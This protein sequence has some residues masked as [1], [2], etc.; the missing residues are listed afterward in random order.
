M[1]QKF[2]G[3][4][5]PCPDDAIPRIVFTTPQRWLD[6]FG[7]G[8]SIRF[9]NR[10]W[11]T[12]PAYLMIKTGQDSYFVLSSRGQR[13]LTRIRKYVVESMLDA[14]EGEWLLKW[15]P[16]APIRE[17]EWNRVDLAALEGRIDVRVNGESIG[18]CSSD[19]GGD[20]LVTVLVCGNQQVEHVRIEEMGYFDPVTEVPFAG[21]PCWLE[22]EIEDRLNTES[23]APSAP[24]KRTVYWLVPLDWANAP[25]RNVR[26]RRFVDQQYRALNDHGREQQVSYTLLAVTSGI[27]YTDDIP[28]GAPRFRLQADGSTLPW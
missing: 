16:R 23:G 9:T 24:S 22:V 7:F 28:A 1:T 17:N 2:P 20:A 4:D 26:V 25:A 14:F 15:G 13:G 10:Q 6:A 11:R 21:A 3:L 5:L 18:G 12:G 8:L 27:V 19:T